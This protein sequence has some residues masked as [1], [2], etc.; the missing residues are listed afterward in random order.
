MPA[1]MLAFSVYIKEDNMTLESILIGVAALVLGGGGGFVFKMIQSNIESK[2]IRDSYE[3]EISNLKQERD[4]A[5]AAKQSVEKEVGALRQSAVDANKKYE[6]VRVLL[7]DAI[8]ALT[9]LKAY[10]AVDKESKE[11]IKK[12]EETIV[13]G[14]I[15]PSTADE[16]KK[17]LEEIN[18]KNQKYNKGRSEGRSTGKKV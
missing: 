16:F 9:V 8:S 14:E 18:K 10:E 12:L 6:D 15:T 7:N 2:K 3:K 11:K 17:M 4:D 5:V 13:N 1:E